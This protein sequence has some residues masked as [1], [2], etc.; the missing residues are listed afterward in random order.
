MERPC[1]TISFG[2]CCVNVPDLAYAGFLGVDL[3]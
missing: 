1:E 3:L 2:L